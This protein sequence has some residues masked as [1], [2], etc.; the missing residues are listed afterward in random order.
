MNIGQQ[1][2]SIS[3]Q[4]KPSD[5]ACAIARDLFDMGSEPSRGDAGIV[6]RMAFIAG[7]WPDDEIQLGGLCE[8]AMAR[9]ID[10]SL[11]AATAQTGRDPME[12]L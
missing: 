1:E 8:S 3:D 9:R 6:H 4:K 12:E 10:A 2:W 11:K 7:E 5:L